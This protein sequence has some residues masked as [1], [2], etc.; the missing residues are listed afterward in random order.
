M[1]WL[2]P[3]ALATM[4]L[5]M[6]LATTPCSAQ[7][8][9][10]VHQKRYA[11]G[12][13]FEIVIYD[14]DSSQ[15][16]AA[17]RAALD[18]AVRLDAVM[19]NYKPESELSRM[20]LRAH[21]RPVHISHE[22]YEVIERSLFYSQISAGQFDVSVGPVVDLWKAALADGSLPT[23]AKQAAALRC[24][25]YQKIELMP[26]DRIQFHSD[27]MRLDLG[28]I[29]KGYAVDHMV[30]LLK[31]RGIHRA[32]IDAGG[33][34]IYAMNTPPGAKAWS[35]RL[36]DPSGKL[37]PEIMLMNGSVSTSEQSAPSVLQRDA[38]GHIVSPGTGKPLQARYAVSVS[39][40]SATASDALS[41]TLLLLG[42]ARGAALVKT[43]HDVS[44]IWIDSDGQRAVAG[45][46]AAFHF[47]GENR[48]ANI[49]HSTEMTIE[50]AK[51]RKDLRQ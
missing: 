46:S 15:A 26:P 51:A 50:T 1:R 47:A 3:A 49:S 34:T 40:A 35:V 25:G 31:A 12:T 7:S 27:C 6:L 38:P 9:S 44:A 11:M 19:S 29:G 13:V 45:E 30:E 21:F 48:S 22:L 8:S 18:E 10:F 4:S 17:A 14:D 41:T 23:A 33:S 39:T 42:P 37:D 20:N 5:A 28:A 2:K 36:R 16:D 32:Y 43:L 24:V